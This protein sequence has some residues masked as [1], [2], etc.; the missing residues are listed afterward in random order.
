MAVLMMGQGRE[1]VDVEFSDCKITDVGDPSVG[2]QASVEEEEATCGSDD[3]GTGA[4]V[5]RDDGSS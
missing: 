5:C 1:D 4:G 2:E 3:A